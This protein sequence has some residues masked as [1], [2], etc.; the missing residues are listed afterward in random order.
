MEFYLNKEKIDVTLENE[1]TVGEVLKSFEMTCEANNAAVIG[2]ELNNQKI[3]ADNFDETSKQE[4]SDSMIF[5]FNVVTSAAIKQSFK[6]LA[7]IFAELSLQMAEVPVALQSGR[8]KEAHLAIK[9]LADSIDDF[10]HIATLASL[11]N[12]YAGISI[13][14]MQFNDFF[15]DLSPILKD[16]ED[17]LKSND[18]VSVG[19]LSEYEICPRLNAIAKALEEI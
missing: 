7:C 16:F 19:D 8:D 2:I 13:N 1:K 6:E 17:A 11:F 5:S 14:N 18:S 12:E 15:A 10:C 4:L 3:T 9:K